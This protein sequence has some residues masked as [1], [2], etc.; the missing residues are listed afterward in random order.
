MNIHASTAAGEMLRPA[1]K[2]P[3]FAAA[4]VHF[5]NGTERV[6]TFEGR[7]Y[8]SST[9]NIVGARLIDS[10]TITETPGDPYTYAL[11]EGAR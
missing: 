6:M 9:I 2:T 4:L 5:L 10:K 1:I 11:V 7:T 3:E 8:S